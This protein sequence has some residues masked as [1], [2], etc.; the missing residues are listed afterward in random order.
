MS[1]G[2][3]AVTWTAIRG[4][5]ERLP[6]DSRL[7][8]ADVLHPAVVVAQAAGEEEAARLLA[9]SFAERQS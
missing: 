9:A 6:K 2:D 3:Y 8:R 7:H 5:L 1:G 4:L